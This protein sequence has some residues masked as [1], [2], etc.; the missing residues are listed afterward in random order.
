MRFFLVCVTEEDLINLR[1]LAEQQ[2]N[3]RA[4]KIKN[5]ILKQT[6]DIK[7][8][9]SWSLITKKLDIIKES[10]EQI[11]DLVKK[12]DVE[13]GHSQT[14]AVESTTVSWSL[15]DILTHMKG[16]RNFFKILEKDGAVFLNNNPIKALGENKI[17]IK[18]QE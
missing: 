17:S 2:T 7:L 11:G 12:S 14:P 3:Q 13:D 4:L 15:L 5:R 8:A 6:H 10:T 1:K 16:N 18:N 9:E